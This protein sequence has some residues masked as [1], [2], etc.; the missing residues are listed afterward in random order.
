MRPTWQ[1]NKHLRRIY[2]FWVWRKYTHAPVKELFQWY[3]DE[4]KRRIGVY[5][6]PP[7]ISIAAGTPLFVDG[8]GKVT[9]VSSDL[10][11]YYMN[12]PVGIAMNSAKKGE[13]VMINLC[14]LY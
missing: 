2:N 6:P 8:D 12:Q 3:W 10:F 1:R 7:P 14:T 13:Q 9:P 11:G 4:L 5:K